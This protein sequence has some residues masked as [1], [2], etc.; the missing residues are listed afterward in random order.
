MEK[1]VLESI[2]DYKVK[3]AIKRVAVNVSSRYP[4][5]HRILVTSI[6]GKEGKSFVS[7]QLAKVMAEKGK[8]VLYING[9]LRKNISEQMGLAEYLGDEIALDKTI[10]ETEHKRLQVIPSG[11]K[12]VTTI[13]ENK[14]KE[15]LK[16]LSETYD[17]IVIDSPS[18]GEV[19]D[20][21]SIGTYC[22]GILLVVEPEIVEQKTMVR[23][24][25]ELENNG[26]KILGVVLN[27]TS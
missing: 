1:I 5:T 25:D 16:K 3:E 19:A 11:R 9:D 20:A 15:L 7:L 21:I 6:A 4:D 24:K 23:I 2:S 18:V 17:Y 22:D 26:C 10:Y 14:V 27:K 8:K 13:N 12:N